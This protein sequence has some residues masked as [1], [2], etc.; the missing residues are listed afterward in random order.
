MKNAL[1]CSVLITLFLTNCTS[2]FN[3]KIKGSGNVT[4]EERP[5]TP[6]D[7]I[8]VNG[9]FKVYLTQGDTEKVEVE[10]D[11]NLQQYV[12][13]HNEGST[14]VLDIKNTKGVNWGKTTQNNIYIT[15]KNINQL[16]IEGVCT[17]ETRTTL[18]CESL[19]LNVEGVSNSS[20]ELNCDILEAKLVGVGNTEL[21]GEA[22][23]FTAKK[24]GVGS[25]KASD[26][27]AAIVDIKNSGV[28][29]AEVYASQELSMKNSGVGSISYSGDAVIKSIDSEGVGK[30][31]KAD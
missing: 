4:T 21:M 7:K 24:E 29:S 2:I 8:D 1:I 6:F 9:I 10:I 11:D 20:L 19:K 18:V 25:L 26:L 23:E 22:R 3:K 31:R 12:N 16:N 30:I 28:G 14:L 17:V 5:V 13:V 15:L 27:R